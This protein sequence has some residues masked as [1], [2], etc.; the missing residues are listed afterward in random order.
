MC[1]QV[2]VGEGTLIGVGASVIPCINIGNWCTIRAGVAVVGD[3]PEN[4]VIVGVPAR[5]LKIKE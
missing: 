1:G 3:V 4:V 5:V 2:H